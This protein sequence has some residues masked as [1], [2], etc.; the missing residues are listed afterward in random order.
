[1][2]NPNDVPISGVNV[3]DD[4]PPEL[5]ILSASATRGTVSINGQFVGVD[6]G[7]M[8]PQEEVT[9]TVN[10]RLADVDE[11][12][13][14][15]NVAV[16]NVNTDVFIADASASILTGIL[17]LPATGETPQDATTLRWALILASIALM[18]GAGIAYK[19][20]YQRNQ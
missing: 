16:L 18:G 11:A 3:G 4:M 1:V 13:V 15:V 10:T 8:A 17:E 9:I 20:R 6:I 7:D 2:T 12:Q 5:E 14:V 19:R